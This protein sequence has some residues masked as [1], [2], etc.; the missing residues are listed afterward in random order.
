MRPP[1]ML[2]AQTAQG[3]RERVVISSAVNVGRRF[4]SSSTAGVLPAEKGA[5]VPQA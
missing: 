3:R 2:R 4:Q 5:M 1:H